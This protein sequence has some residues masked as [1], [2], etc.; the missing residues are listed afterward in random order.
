VNRYARGASDAAD[1]IEALAGFQR[2]PTWMW[3][4][5]D[6]VDF[7]EWLRR[8]N[9]LR[10]PA[11][12]K[13]GFYGLDLYSLHASMAAV[14]DYLQTVDPEAARLAAERYA[15]FESLGPE[16][17]IYGFIATAD[18]D[19]SCEE[20]VVKQLLELQRRAA[21]AARRNAAASDDDLFNPEQNA[22]V[23][24][25]AER[26]SRS[27][28]LEETSSW[29]L[30]DRHM[31]DTLEAVAGYIAQRGRHPKIVVWAHNSHLGDARFT[32]MSRRG[33]VNLGQL[34]REPHD[35]DAV[36][37]G[38]TTDHGTVTAA[39][40]WGAVARRKRVRPAVRES[41]EALFHAARPD[42]FLLAW[43][44]DDPVA[45]HLHMVRL[46]RAIG[47]I[48]RPD[49]E[50]ISHYFGAD[51]K[52]Q[53]DAVLH[54]DETAAVKPLELLAEWEPNEVPETFP[55]GV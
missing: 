9:E 4:N 52:N 19:R 15:C 40:E 42:R 28:F 27:M 6:V 29:N 39:S 30:R 54:F 34:V 24:R 32:E 17:Q 33:E 16:P 26:Y 48:Y 35:G 14:L 3:R 36:L 44:D 47:V 25:D 46:E 31:M 2:F 1:A 7:V 8:H 23:V 41:H 43:R 53:F 11:A 10:S 12:G 38:F 20:D 50:R 37:V 13:V 18:V 5:T 21:E 51:L 22:R 49:T 45:V 55:S